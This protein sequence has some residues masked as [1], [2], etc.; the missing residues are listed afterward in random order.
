MATGYRYSSSWRCARSIV[1]P[2]DNDK[3]HSIYRAPYLGDNCEILFGPVENEEG[4]IVW[5]G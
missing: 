5:L 3:I 1:N 2:P 4:S